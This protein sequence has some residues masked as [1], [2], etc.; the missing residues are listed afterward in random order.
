MYRVQN[1]EQFIL[2]NSH[3]FIYILLLILIIFLVEILH[4]ISTPRI[5][6]YK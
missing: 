2:S 1:H 5:Y 3:D 6:R 4:I